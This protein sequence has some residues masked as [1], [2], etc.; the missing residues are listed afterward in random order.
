MDEY[1]KMMQ[2]LEQYLA[3]E[4]IEDTNEVISAYSLYEIVD[5]GFEKLRN[6]YNDWDFRQQINTDKVQT[7]KKGFIFKKTTSVIQNECERVSTTADYKTAQMHIRFE[8]YNHTIILCKDRNSQEIYFDKYSK[9]DKDFISKYYDYI[10]E[11][12]RIAEEYVDL[13][14]GPIGSSRNDSSIQPQNFPVSFFYIALEYTRSGEVSIDII[15][16]SEKDPDGIAKREW[17]NRKKIIDYISENETELLKK[18]PIHVEQLVPTTK[19]IVEAKMN[20]SVKTFTLSKQTK[21]DI[22]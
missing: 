13:I 22:N 20:N 7:I 3:R 2:E 16:D 18:I 9:I 21:N 6:I 11:T 12:F 8:Y 5:D 15:V 1:E 14:G 10:M 19:K 4:D 17:Y